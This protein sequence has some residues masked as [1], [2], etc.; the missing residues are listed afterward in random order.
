MEQLVVSTEKLQINDNYLVEEEE[1]EDSENCCGIC[2]EK[3]NRDGEDY[4]KLD[5]GHEFCYSCINDSFCYIA[6][7]NKVS[8]TNNKRECP[9]CRNINSLIPLKMGYTPVKGVHKMVI[10]STNN[11]IPFQRCLA[12]CKTGKKCKNRGKSEYGGYC[13]IHKKLMGT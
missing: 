5:C 8:S 3:I 6:T 12:T 4:I 11:D 10:K 9:Y 7:M 13:G 1:E 2:T